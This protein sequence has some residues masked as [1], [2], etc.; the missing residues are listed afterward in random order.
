MQIQPSERD[1]IAVWFGSGLSVR[2]I[3]KRLDR[4]P[5]TICREL[6]RN[7]WG[8]GYES[9][10]AQRISSRRKSRVNKTHPQKDKWVYVYVLE[11]LKEGWSPEQISGRLEREHGKKIIHWETIYRWVYGDDHQER[12]FWEY[13]P[14]KRKRRHKKYGRKARRARIPNRVSIHLRDE[15]VND[16]K[17]FGHWESDSVIGRQTKS[18]VIH[19]EVERKTRYLQAMVINSKSAEDTVAAQKQIFTKLPT[20]TVTMDNG[21][22]FVKHKELAKLGIKTYFADPYC[23]G[24]RGTNENTNGLIRRYLPKKT[25]F[26]N[27]AQEDLDDIV[28]EINNRPRK[29][30]KFST[31][32]EVLQQSL[33]V[34]GVAFQMR[35]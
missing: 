33:L 23:S 1:K 3:A 15:S 22:E 20:K 28:F 14:L 12:K 21:T 7:R 29:V 16:R 31:P 19:T 17:T 27:L 32:F 18:K 34:N 10:K 4:S 35:M 30:L 9:I 6:E 11:K 13:L 2:E 24:Q 8:D 5:S 26:D 25:S